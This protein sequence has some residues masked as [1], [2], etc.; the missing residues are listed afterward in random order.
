[1][2]VVNNKPMSPQDYYRLNLISIENN[3]KLQFTFMGMLQFL[4]EKKIIPKIM[5]LYNENYK[6]EF[7]PSGY[8]IYYINEEAHS[9]QI[10]QICLCKEKQNQEYAKKFLD[11]IKQDFVDYDITAHVKTYNTQSQAF[12]AKNNFSFI[13][14]SEKERWKVEWRKKK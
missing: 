12:F 8:C 3:D 5:V 4:F 14:E 7:L 11:R 9:C 1:M 13:E 6:E 10:S 2:I